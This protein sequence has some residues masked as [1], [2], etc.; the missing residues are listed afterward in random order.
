MGAWFAG[1]VYLVGIF[2]YEGAS[3]VG[4]PV[5][6]SALAK[7]SLTPSLLR[8]RMPSRIFRVKNPSQ[9]VVGLLESVSGK[10]VIALYDHCRD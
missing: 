7:R 10:T 8:G 9:E 4:L 6:F 2:E 3:P 5:S 1:F